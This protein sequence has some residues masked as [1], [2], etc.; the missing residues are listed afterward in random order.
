MQQD[1]SM[2]FHMDSKSKLGTGSFHIHILPFS[3]GKGRE[4]QV[5]ISALD[6][7]HNKL[8]TSGKEIQHLTSPMPVIL[9]TDQCKVLLF[10]INE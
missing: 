2:Q 6:W 9:E 4:Q 7:V 10:N 5:E 8:K 3:G 1:S